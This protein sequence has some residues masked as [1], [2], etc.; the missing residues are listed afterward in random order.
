MKTRF[1][2]SFYSFGIS[3]QRL[4]D[5]PSGCGGRKFAQPCNQA[6][7]ES[8]TYVYFQLCG[9]AT[10]GGFGKREYNFGNRT[11][12]VF[13]WRRLVPIVDLVTTASSEELVQDGLI[14]VGGGVVV[15]TGGHPLQLI[16]GIR[17]LVNVGALWVRFSHGRPD[18]K[19]DQD[20]PTN[21]FDS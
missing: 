12:L 21:H 17:S 14:D 10:V 3:I 6:F 5:P 18:D 4:H 16:E 2:L 1:W 9:P 11:N 8:C 20:E 19:G 15:T 7:A 13:W